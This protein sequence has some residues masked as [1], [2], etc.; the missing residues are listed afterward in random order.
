MAAPQD[1]PQDQEALLALI[2]KAIGVGFDLWLQCRT[3][4][5]CGLSAKTL[6]L[7]YYLEIL[8][9]SK[10]IKL[11][12]Q[13]YMLPSAKKLMR[14]ILDRSAHIA[15]IQNDD[16]K[17][18]RIECDFLRRSIDRIKNAGEVLQQN[19]NSELLSRVDK[20]LN[21]IVAV[22]EKLCPDVKAMPR[23][24]TIFKKAGMEYEYH[25][26]HSEFSFG[27]HG[28]CFEEFMM[29]NF[30]TPSL[31]SVCA[32]AS[33]DRYDIIGLAVVLAKEI[34]RSTENISKVCGAPH[35]AEFDAIRN[36]IS[37]SEPIKRSFR[38]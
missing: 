10:A 33:Q 20:V 28:N 36:A 34:V 5:A 30:E 3:E 25:Y 1:Q 13:E 6:C 8:Q 32:H 17:T 38:L 18:I 9:D 7:A 12:L 22:K 19:E 31:E 15:W 11:L 27:I 16:L 26:Y 2:E 14:Q 23:L 4:G 35:N 29:R 37:K 21:T 24:N